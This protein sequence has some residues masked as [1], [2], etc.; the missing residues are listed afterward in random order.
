VGVYI[1]APR[2]DRMSAT[3]VQ[4][5][6]VLHMATFAAAAPTQ[7]RLGCSNSDGSYAS[8]QAAFA[9]KLIHAARAISRRL[10]GART[11]TVIPCEPRGS[12]AGLL[13]ASIGPYA[14]QR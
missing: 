10:V 6:R 1:V 14:F 7:R 8:S 11:T 9:A 12:A 5:R 3:P 2:S 13:S 4:L